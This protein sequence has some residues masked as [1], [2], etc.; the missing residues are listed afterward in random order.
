MISRKLTKPIPGLK[1]NSPRPFHSHYPP[2]PFSPH[3][4]TLLIRYVYLIQFI[5]LILEYLFLLI[6]INGHV[7][8]EI[9][10]DDVAM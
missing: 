8:S 10:L 3:H 5:I 9:S 1:T 6:M 7:I 2:T 4:P